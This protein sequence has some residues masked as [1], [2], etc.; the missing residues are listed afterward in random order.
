MK[1]NSLIRRGCAVGLCA[2]TLTGTLALGAMAASPSQVTAQLSPQI[3]VEVDGVARTFYNVNGQ[4]VQP[5]AYGGTTYLPIRA[6]G[7]LMDKNVNWD[8]ST[9]T[10]SLSGTRTAPDASGTPDAD[11][12]SRSVQ[13]Q[14]RPDFTVLVDGVER[15]FTDANGK[16]VYPL[17]YDGS[18]Y[19]PIRAMG[20]LMGKSVGWEQATLTATLT[21]PSGSLV[22]D[23]DSFQNTGSSQTGSSQTGSAQT[24]SVTAETAKANALAHAGLA[25][26]QVTFTKCK[27]DR[28]NGVQVYDVEFYTAAG[29]KY[30]YE[31][32]ADGGAVVSMDYDAPWAAQSGGTL[33]GTE[34]AK[35]F[36]LA[37]VPGADSSA[38]LRVEL[39]RD[40][41][42]QLYEVKIRFD[43]VEHELDIDGYTG[44]VRAWQFE[45]TGW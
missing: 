27:L 21:A 29:A 28:E 44:A 40:D 34:K 3:T 12:A 25:Q 41:G 35:S 7:E 6:M 22:T 13:V 9:L 18:V 32:K 30:E 4:E 24:G 1:K 14:L 39:D 31:I 38:V 15:T 16:T 11:A 26:S 8:Q 43:G 36:A 20:E 45:P 2:L 37:K 19:L 23:A 17:L 10:V 42:V 5:I 33:I